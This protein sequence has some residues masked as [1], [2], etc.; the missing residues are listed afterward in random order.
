MAQ[1]VSTL[2]LG[3]AV[4]VT[5]HLRQ[6]AHDGGRARVECRDDSRFSY[7]VICQRCNMATPYC[8]QPSLAIAIW[9]RR[10]KRT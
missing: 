10:I 5:P 7:R 9:N 3:P 2:T 6:C 4:N 8:T 1:A